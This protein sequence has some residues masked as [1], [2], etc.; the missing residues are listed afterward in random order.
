MGEYYVLTRYLL[1]CPS[2]AKVEDSA[3]KTWT[4]NSTDLFDADV[5]L[6]DEDDLLDENDL[7]KPD[8]ASLKGTIYVQLMYS[9]PWLIISI[10]Y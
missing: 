3:A 2:T 10:P 7:K 8:P 5:D 1:F 4:L 6:V 9:A